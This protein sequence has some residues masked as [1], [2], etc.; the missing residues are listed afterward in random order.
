MNR[1]QRTEAIPSRCLSGGLVNDKAAE[2][3]FERIPSS[4][5]P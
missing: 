5:I 1:G 2:A 4:C 3:A